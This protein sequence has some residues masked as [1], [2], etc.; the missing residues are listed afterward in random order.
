MTAADRQA[1]AA[2]QRRNDIALW[3][4][5]LTEPAM[6]PALT[7][8][9]RGAGGAG[10]GVPRAPGPGREEGQ[11]VAA[12]DRPVEPRPRL[13]AA[14][15][16][17]STPRTS[18][19]RSHWERSRLASASA[20]CAK[21]RSGGRRASREGYPAQIQSWQ[22][23]EECDHQSGYAEMVVDGQHQRRCRGPEQQ[24]QHHRAWPTHAVAVPTLHSTFP[25][26]ALR[27]QGVFIMPGLALGLTSARGRPITSLSGDNPHH[28]GMPP[29]RTPP[30]RRGPVSGYQATAGTRGG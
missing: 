27:A 1:A 4:W 12:D 23:K 10:P 18:A 17:H 2:R 13:P 19:S 21:L 3:R 9:Q 16:D 15:R 5:A 28:G 20:T 8:R 7:S 24:S 11:R 22:S 30:Q 14:D 25:H 6:D 26:S 29:A